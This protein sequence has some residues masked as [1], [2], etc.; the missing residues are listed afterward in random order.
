MTAPR[1]TSTQGPTAAL[2]K[3][4]AY[5]RPTQPRSRLLAQTHW[6]LFIL[7]HKFIKPG[8]LQL[9]FPVPRSC[10][11]GREGGAKGATERETSRL[12]AAS[13]AVNDVYLHSLAT[14][15]F[16]EWQGAPVPMNIFFSLLFWRIVLQ[17]DTAK[18]DA[19]SAFAN[20]LKPRVCP[21][22]PN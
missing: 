14:V 16:K 6:G 13:L 1:V 5:T 9:V 11:R 22:Q 17:Y 15:I 20:I 19:R 2:L 18:G 21:G 3:G 10:F 8:D 12:T 7:R 4:H